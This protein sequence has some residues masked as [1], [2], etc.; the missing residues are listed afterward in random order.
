MPNHCSLCQTTFGHWSEY[1]S[2]MRTHHN[3]SHKVNYSM[4]PVNT[5]GRT[6]KQIVE[7]A[8]K[9]WLKP[10]LLHEVHDGECRCNKCFQ[11]ALDNLVNTSERAVNEF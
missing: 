2:H 8:E 6:K 3:V 9:A 4:L 1:T 5:S 10:G 11:K 7:E